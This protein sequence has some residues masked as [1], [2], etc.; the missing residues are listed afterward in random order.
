MAIKDIVKNLCSKLGGNSKSIYPILAISAANGI[1]RP[2]FTMMKKG[3]NPESKKYA[4]LREGIT[5]VVAMPTYFAV[6]M[7]GEKFGK[8]IA[9]KAVDKD[10]LKREAAGE[11]IADA[12]KK[13]MKLAAGKKGA[14]GLQ[15]I[16]LCI[17]A[18]III[19]AV[20]SAVVTPIMSKIG[21]KPDAKKALDIKENAVQETVMPVKTNIKPIARPTFNNF[22]SGMKVG[23]V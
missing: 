6:G 10:I 9:E 18:G 4:A 8:M 12:V 3:E 19:P 17:A 13:E 16:S 11:T 15:L 1:F 23:G 20:C 14:S 7:L 21:K 22:S 5:E 2:T